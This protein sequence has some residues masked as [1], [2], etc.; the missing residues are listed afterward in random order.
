MTASFASSNARSLIVLYIQKEC[1]KFS[2]IDDVGDLQW[3]EGLVRFRVHTTRDLRT[4]PRF[5]E[6]AG[7]E[8]RSCM[9]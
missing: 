8:S 7:V 3:K 5:S 1:Y 6:S 4:S 2:D 9:E